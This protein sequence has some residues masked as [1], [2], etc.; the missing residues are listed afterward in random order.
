MIHYSLTLP[1]T[2]FHKVLSLTISR[3]ANVLAS[4]CSTIFSLCFLIEI[5]LKAGE[6]VNSHA[7]VGRGQNVQTLG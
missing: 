1:A 5:L 6:V 4:P 3:D 2:D 7:H